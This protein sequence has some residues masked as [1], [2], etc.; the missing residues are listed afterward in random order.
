[1]KFKALT[2]VE[3]IIIVALAAFIILAIIGG[4][5]NYKYSHNDH[6]Y[7]ITV[8]EK[9]RI[10]KSGDGGQESQ[11]Y[12][13]IFA[14]DN[15]NGDLIELRIKDVPL[16]DFYQSSVLYNKLEVGKSYTVTCVGYR[17]YRTSEYENIIAIKE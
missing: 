10:Y 9:E 12:Y 5:I 8:R 11:S 7:N 17:N 6:D 1:M 13:L 14:K 2:V 3:I 15:D 16:R 4:V